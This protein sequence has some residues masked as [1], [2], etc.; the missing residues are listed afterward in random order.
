MRKILIYLGEFL[1]ADLIFWVG[2]FLS[3]L[4]VLMGPN[5]LAE[6]SVLISFS[7][8]PALMVHGVAKATNLK[9]KY[10][11]GLIG[12]LLFAVLA[13]LILYFS[14]PAQ[15]TAYWMT[16]VPYYFMPVIGV[17]PVLTYNLFRKKS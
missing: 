11:H 16:R 15:A 7:F 3:Q 2:L 10:W 9:G 17:G 4:T 8:L 1:L 5:Y 14:E 12:S 13:I 6:S